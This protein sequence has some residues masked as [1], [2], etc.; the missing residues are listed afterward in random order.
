[1]RDGVL[2]RREWPLWPRGLHQALEDV[3]KTACCQLLSK[4]PLAVRTISH[5]IVAQLSVRAQRNRLY[6][7]LHDDLHQGLEQVPA[8]EGFRP[9]PATLRRGAEAAKEPACQLSYSLKLSSG[10]STYASRPWLGLPGAPAYPP[11]HG[12]ACGRKALPNG[13]ALRAG[14]GPEKPCTRTEPLPKFHSHD[15]PPPPPPPSLPL[16][17]GCARGGWGMSDELVGGCAPPPPKKLNSPPRRP[18]APLGSPSSP[19]AGGRSEF[20]LGLG[21]GRP[22]PYDGRGERP[23]GGPGGGG[24]RPGRVGGGVGSS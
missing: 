24:T 3:I 15:L 11:T 12:F 17:L 14:M 21:S 18:P 7:L 9:T 8:R 1:M 23:G 4:Y 19:Y 2:R 10:A 6:A 13:L 22:P 5:D 16:P 20:G